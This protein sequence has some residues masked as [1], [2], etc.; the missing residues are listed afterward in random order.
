MPHE[1][2]DAPDL[3]PGLRAEVS[4]LVTPER[5]AAALGNDAAVRV[6]ATPEMALLVEDACAAALAV[7]LP[8]GTHGVGTFLEIRHLEATPVGCTVTARVVL[9]AMNGR[10]LTFHAELFDEAGKVGE[11]VH[12]RMI[13]DWDRFLARLQQRHD[14]TT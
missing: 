6:F 14:G 1:L 9:T 3:Q 10:R 4:R 7:R 11:A 8:P 13:V 12:E 2:S 5:T